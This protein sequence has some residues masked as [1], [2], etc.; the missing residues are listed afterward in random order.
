MNLLASLSGPES[1]SARGQGMGSHRALHSC[2]PFA[3]AWSCPQHRPQKCGALCAADRSPHCSGNWVW[4]GKQFQ[5]LL[6]P[7]PS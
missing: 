6:P 5:G 1:P 7:N 2:H 4:K 3:P